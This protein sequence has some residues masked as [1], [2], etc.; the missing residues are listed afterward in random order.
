MSDMVA[1]DGTKTE[2]EVMSYEPD[3]QGPAR[4]QVS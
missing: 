4:S 3:G 2:L 1:V